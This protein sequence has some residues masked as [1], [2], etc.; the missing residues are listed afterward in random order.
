ME[1]NAETGGL[2]SLKNEKNA[3]IFSHLAAMFLNV[4]SSCDRLEWRAFVELS[5]L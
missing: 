2:P 4:H 3:K 5:V 1:K